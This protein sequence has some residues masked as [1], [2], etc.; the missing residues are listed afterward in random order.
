VRWLHPSRRRF[1]PPQDEVLN[2]HGEERR[3]R[4]SND[5]AYDA[6]AFISA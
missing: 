3:R 5:E 1:A 4:V 6:S 2:P